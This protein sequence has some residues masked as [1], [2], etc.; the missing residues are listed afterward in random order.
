MY[1]LYVSKRCSNCVRFIEAMNQNELKKFTHIVDIDEFRVPP[2]ISSIP[3][4]VSN[5]GRI[6]AG[7]AA[8][9]VMSQH[10]TEIDAFD[11]DQFGKLSWG[12]IE[13]SKTDYSTGFWKIESE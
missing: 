4:L 9:E 12:A 7:K 13:N 5:D 1:T 6:F 11:I 8:F 3:T 2:G 10:A